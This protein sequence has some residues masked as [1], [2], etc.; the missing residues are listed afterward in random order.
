[1][2]ILSCE[3]IRQADRFTIENEPIASVDLME[4]A[5]KNCFNWIHEKF[6]AI[7]DY[8]VFCGQGNN[9]GDGLV[10]ARMLAESGGCV[11]VYIIDAGGKFSPD[12]LVNQKRLKK[13]SGVKTIIISDEKSLT[14]LP[15]FSNSGIRPVIIDAIFG[16]GLSRLTEGI[17][18]KTIEYINQSKAICI[19]I[20]IP[21]GLFGEDNSTNK[22][23]HVVKADITLSLQFPKLSM[24]LPAF[25][26]SVGELI[27]IPIGLHDDF[28]GQV[29]TPYRI[30]ESSEIAQILQPRSKFSHKGTFGHALLIAGS[31]GKAGAAILS[32]TAALRSGCG[33]LTVHTPKCNYAPVHAAIPEAMLTCGHDDSQVEGFIDTSGFT[34]VGVGPG[35][36]TMKNTQQAI[37]LLIQNCK[38][39]MVFDADALNILG[40]N[41]TWLSFL[42]PGSILTPHPKEFERMFRTPGS[43]FSRLEILKTFTAKNN[44]IVIL[45][46]AYTTIAFPDGTFRFNPTGNPGMA[47]AGSGDVLTGII[48]SMLAQGYSAPEAAIA[49]VYLHGLAGNLA[50]EAYGYE[51]LIASDITN[52]LGG[53]FRLIHSNEE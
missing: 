4:R 51:A 50:A 43:D 53:A 45:K 30:T 48:L 11:S 40:E 23:G 2:K 47:T 32:A 1:M 33:L 39:P 35:I 38:V 37:K 21:S 52:N 12:F 26:N 44:C 9:G 31:M 18:L 10:I 28:I 17:F 20:D 15:E 24:M 16:S 19:S 25:G 29:A 34:A 27:T 41:K 5:G 6:G 7:H 42:P 36:G 22:P 46:G 8:H 3:Q 13:I 14:S 49:G